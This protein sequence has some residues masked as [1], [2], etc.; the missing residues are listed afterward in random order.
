[1]FF[2]FSSAGSTADAELEY[3]LDQVRF[4][5]CA[6]PRTRLGAETHINVTV[7]CIALN[8]VVLDSRKCEHVLCFQ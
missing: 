2:V 4:T 6:V 8:Q 1:M 5:L 3:S 7:E